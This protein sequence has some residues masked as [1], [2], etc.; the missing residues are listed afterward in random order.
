MRFHFGQ[1][2]RRALLVNFCLVALMGVAM[3]AGPEKTIR[4][5]AFGDSLMAGF[6]LKPGEGFPEQLARLLK[7]KG[8]SFEMSNAGVSGDTT[9]AGLSRIDWAV[10]DGT[11]A[12]ILELG[13]NDALQGRPPADTRRNL[14][15]ILTQL[16][17][18]GIAVLVAGMRAPRN[19]GPEYTAAF[20]S[21]FP[22]L[23][24][25]HGALLYPF[26]LEGVAL[27]PKLNLA[28]GI[29]PTAAGISIIAERM[30]P[31]VEELIARVRAAAPANG[32][33]RPRG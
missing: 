22:E 17:G 29:H 28:D 30:L 16:K 27:D 8:H 14:D 5:V 9:V 3:A 25:K 19:L 32:Q 26:V 10:P 4:I 23:A 2:V 20:D 12:V 21:I 13:A 31:Q 18:R 1:M 6:G 11:D 24:A 15:A 33:N 7:A